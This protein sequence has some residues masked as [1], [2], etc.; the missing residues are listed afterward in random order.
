MTA[1]KFYTVDALK[2]EFPLVLETSLQEVSK[3]GWKEGEF[4]LDLCYHTGSAK[5]FYVSFR[6][7]LKQEIL[8]SDK[9][10][11]FT[12]TYNLDKRQVVRTVQEDLDWKE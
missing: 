7:P 9:A 11:I 3:H 1:W 8:D 10:F 6:K 5:I 4:E 12:V 2:D